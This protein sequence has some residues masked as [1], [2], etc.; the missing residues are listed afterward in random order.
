MDSCFF[1]SLSAFVLAWENA[2]WSDPHDYDPGDG[3]AVRP[4]EIHKGKCPFCP[5]YTKQADSVLFTHIRD[6]HTNM[7]YRYTCRDGCG[8]GTSK[9]GNW[10]RHWPTCNIFKTQLDTPPS[11]ES[12]SSSDSSSD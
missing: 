12:D 2:W 1:F 7:G 3:W 5:F 8:F 9:W 4:P 11:S 10:E 6:Y